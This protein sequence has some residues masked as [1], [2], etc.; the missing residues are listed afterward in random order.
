MSDSRTQ[1][2]GEWLLLFKD[3]GYYEEAGRVR[4]CDVPPAAKCEARPPGNVLF[5]AA[6][7]PADIVVSCLTE[8]RQSARAPPLLVLII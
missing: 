4:C 7:A 1:N 6:A 3:R 2:A 8:S 5:D